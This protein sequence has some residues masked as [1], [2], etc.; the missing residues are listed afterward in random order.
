[1]G[2][3]LVSISDGRGQLG[4]AFGYNYFINLSGGDWDAIQ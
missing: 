3:G 2:S 4:D 1:M